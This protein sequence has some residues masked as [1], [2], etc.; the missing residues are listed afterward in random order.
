MAN[1]KDYEA[2]ARKIYEGQYASKIQG[3]K[4][5]QKLQNQQYANDEKKYNSQYDKY[6][7]ENKSQGIK[8]QNAYNNNT[9][10]RGLGRSSIATTGL[11]G[12]QLATDKAEREINSERASKLQELINAR[13]LYNQSIQDQ[14][15]AIESEKIGAISEYARK[16]YEAQ[17]E[18]EL[19]QQ[20]AY[21]SR[22]YSSGG[23]YSSGGIS[24]NDVSA[25]MKSMNDE[26]NSYINSG[27]T[28]KARD[29]LFQGLRAYQ[30]GLITAGTYTN[31]QNK[32]SAL[33]KKQLA[34]N[35]ANK[36]KNGQ[37]LSYGYRNGVAGYY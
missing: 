12:I 10:S 11:S 34:Q 17:V 22:S 9:L 7:A 15:N 36:K 6:L 31:M 26:F 35:T 1:L 23:G 24:S 8:N 21:A 18:R 13:N 2:E 14:L 25:A 3:I 33:E 5:Q 4:N 30:N 20:L 16:L 37:K 28:R 29:V 32:L 27:D 19:Q